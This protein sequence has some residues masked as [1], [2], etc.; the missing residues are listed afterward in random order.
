MPN[1]RTDVCYT[2]RVGSLVDSRAR[3]PCAA[4]HRNPRPSVME[5]WT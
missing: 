3:T 5:A 2:Q 1:V 4:P